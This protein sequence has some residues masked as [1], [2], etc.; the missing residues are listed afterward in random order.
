MPA[1]LCHQEWQILQ[2]LCC[3][4]LGIVI[5]DLAQPKQQI[6]QHWLAN[7]LKQVALAKDFFGMCH[8]IAKEEQNILQGRGIK[9]AGNSQAAPWLIL[10]F[11]HKSLAAGLKPAKLHQ[12]FVT[13]WVVKET[14]TLCSTPSPSKTHRPTG[15]GLVPAD[16]MIEATN[17]L[18]NDMAAA[19]SSQESLLCLTW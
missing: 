18:R 10:K 2:R 13:P 15:G 16:S 6:W 11:G 14:S 9:G 7:I 12:S 19:L 3:Q 4:V 8:Q 17:L 5:H 1:T